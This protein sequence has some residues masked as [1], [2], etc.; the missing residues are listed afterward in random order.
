MKS[1]KNNVPNTIVLLF[2]HKV[3]VRNAVYDL[4]GW[5]SRGNVLLMPMVYEPMK[6]F[7]NMYLFSGSPS[8]FSPT[9]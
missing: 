5:S 2:S 4:H 7:D 8:W 3:D 9:Q 1:C 6:H